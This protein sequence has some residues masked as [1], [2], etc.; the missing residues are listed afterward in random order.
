MSG[1][2]ALSVLRDV[3]GG[4][5]TT[6]RPVAPSVEAAQ[7]GGSLLRRGPLYGRIKKVFVNSKTWAGAV[8]VL[9]GTYDISWDDEKNNPLTV[10][11]PIS[12]AQIGR[13]PQPPA[14]Y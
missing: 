11:L 8:Q 7:T 3:C 1:H 14:H 9:N 2:V 4:A 5:L 13:M 6:R 12:L 10:P